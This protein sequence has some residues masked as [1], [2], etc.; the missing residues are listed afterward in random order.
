[1]HRGVAADRLRVQRRDEQHHPGRAEEHP[2]GRGDFR[3]QTDRDEHVQHR[4]DA[5]GGRHDPPAGRGETGER[6]QRLVPRVG[7]GPRGLG[8]SETDDEHRRREHGE[9]ER[10][11]PGA[12]PRPAHGSAP[13]RDRDP[14]RPHRLHQ[15]DRALGGTEPCA[16]GPGLR[17]QPRQA[18]RHGR[19]RDGGVPSQ[20]GVEAAVGGERDRPGD[21]GEQAGD[22][23]GHVDRRAAVRRLRGQ[24]GDDHGHAADPQEQACR[25]RDVAQPEGHDQ[26]DHAHGGQD[27]GHDPP[28]GRSPAGERA[29]GLADRVVGPRRLHGLRDQPA[30]DQQ[31]GR[32]DGQRHHDRTPQALARSLRGHHCHARSP[33]P[34]V[35]TRRL[36]HDLAAAHPALQGHPSGVRSISHVR[37]PAVS[38]TA[39]R[40]TSNPERA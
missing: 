37:G 11:P 31:E 26:V 25:A 33:L 12:A 29:D 24:G 3:A 9:R 18:R 15:E 30:D 4:G 10:R 36:P 38:G 13:G 27:R 1:M 40:T 8:G 19:E 35:S 2:G 17:A 22:R 5:E 39:S 16:V 14:D 34:L 7:P 32:R 6:A 28:V 20:A 23:R 21:E